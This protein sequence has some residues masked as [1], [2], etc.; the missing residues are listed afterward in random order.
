MAT[1]QNNMTGQNG[2]GGGSSGDYVN[3]MMR[4]MQ[5]GSAMRSSRMMQ[6]GMDGDSMQGGEG[7]REKLEYRAKM[8]KYKE[9]H[10]KA[11]ETFKTITGET[12][13]TREGAVKALAWIMKNKSYTQAAE[14]IFA[15]NDFCWAC[16]E[17]EAEEDVRE[18]V[19]TLSGLMR[20]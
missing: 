6:G 12:V 15:S 16:D 14:A 4:S 10:D 2:M 8:K 17:K 11:V 19:S 18:E 3:G 1:D 9:K 5:G 20:G 7:V 13:E